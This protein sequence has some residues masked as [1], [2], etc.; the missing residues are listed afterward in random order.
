MSVQFIYI[1]AD[2]V[3]VRGA[4][5]IDIK[6]CLFFFLRLIF[7]VYSNSGKYRGESTS[8]RKFTKRS[9]SCFCSQPDG[10]VRWHA[11]RLCIPSIH[12]SRHPPIH[13]S[14]HSSTHQPINPSTHQT[15]IHQPEKKKEN[16]EDIQIQNPN[17]N[18]N[19]K[20]NPNITLS[21]PQPGETA[22]LIV[23]GEA[24]VPLRFVLKGLAPSTRYKVG[25]W[26]GG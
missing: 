20:P 17:P 25:R 26:A 19:R 3:V 4:S 21:I 13:S 11:I 5:G 6:R 8:S 24:L 1:V 15:H 12:S 9:T 14:I 22:A 7:L 10:M 16:K 18:P 2:L 23:I